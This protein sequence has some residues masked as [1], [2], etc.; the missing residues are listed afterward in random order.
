MRRVVISLIVLLIVV[1]GGFFAL[2]AYVIASAEKKFI[3]RASATGAATPA[4]FGVAWTPLF[5]D[6]DGRRLEAS[7]VM[8]P[9][10]CGDARGRASASRPRRIHFRLG[11]GAGVPEQAVRVVDHVRL[12]G[13][14]R[15]SGRADHRQFERR[16][17]RGLCRVRAEIP[18][19]LAA[20]RART[21]HGQCACAARLSVLCAAARLRRDGERVQLR[22][23][24]RALERRAVAVRAASPRR[25]GQHARRSST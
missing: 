2:R 3:G 25:L 19:A 8:A 15:Q 17:G 4:Q 13:Q 23:G 5:I 16:C 24:F 6:S 9:S 18:E 1:A 22:R 21:F 11:Q 20:L 14:W 7:L 10:S 12:F